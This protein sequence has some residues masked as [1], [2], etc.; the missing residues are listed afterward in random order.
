LKKEI[1][2]AG[3]GLLILVDLWT[4]DKRYLKA[5]NFQD[6][7]AAISNEFPSERSGSI[8]F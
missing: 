5:D 6:A 4:V 3:L 8:L 2:I 7:K 1:M